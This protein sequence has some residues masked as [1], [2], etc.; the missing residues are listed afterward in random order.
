MASNNAPSKQNIK[1]N[2][3]KES[4]PKI[5]TWP[6]ENWT[7]I[8]RGRTDENPANEELYRMRESMSMLLIMISGIV[9]V[10]V[11]M[12]FY[13]AKKEQEEARKSMVLNNQGEMVNIQNPEEE[14]FEYDNLKIRNTGGGSENGSNRGSKLSERLYENKL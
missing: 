13:Y 4:G 1:Q 7:D 12:K 5:W 11:S 2:N 9:F 14:L 10:W 8:F 6:F 3:N